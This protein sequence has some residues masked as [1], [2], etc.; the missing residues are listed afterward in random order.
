MKTERMVC[1][2]RWL[3]LFGAASLAAALT[4]ASPA[5]AWTE[6]GMRD[7][8]QWTDSGSPYHWAE[9]AIRRV[10]GLEIMQGYDAG[11]YAV[12]DPQTGEN[13]VLRVQPDFH[14]ERPI[15]RA[16]FGAVLARAT[17]AEETD[18]TAVPSSFRD[19]PAGAW[20]E[21]DLLPLVQ[22]GILRLDDYPSGSLYPDG[23]ITR[24]EMATWVAR[25]ARAYGIGL[26]AGGAARSFPDVP[27]AYPHRDGLAAAAALH[28]V[29]G[30]PDG[31]FRPDA[32]ATRAEA[33]VMMWRLIQFMRASPPGL[34]QLQGV[35]QAGEDAFRRYAHDTMGLRKVYD[36]LRQRT[37][38]YFTDPNLT[39]WYNPD[40]AD[41][42][43]PI[44]H[45][46]ASMGGGDI[47]GA[48]DGWGSGVLSLW[49]EYLLDQRVLGT[50]FGYSAAV[51]VQVRPVFL[52]DRYAILDT[53]F[54]SQ[55]ELRS[56]VATPQYRI[57]VEES[58][59]L[60]H[61]TWKRCAHGAETL[62]DE[63]PPDRPWIPDLLRRFDEPGGAA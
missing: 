22:Q 31:T 6:Y 61:G 30:Y 59:R 57:R 26:P 39:R 17:G 46:A 42:F 8:P 12:R 51:Y 49:Q 29:E 34:D 54:I 43:S 20:Y 55:G 52:G 53:E 24:A 16:E 19:T 41:H 14:P 23:A 40:Y 27:A 1:L 32:T 5:L 38:P 4:C 21:R 33:T 48:P 56:G 60:D 44:P 36:G 37:G 10:T 18:S 50:D 28:I 45:L 2:R 58:L 9:E 62:V 11:A 15:T 25:A 3:L 63:T 7:S 35:L 47:Q 13:T